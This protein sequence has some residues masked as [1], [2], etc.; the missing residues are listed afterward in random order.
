MHK[1]LYVEPRLVI[2]EDTISYA[3]DIIPRGNEEDRHELIE[4]S[5]HEATKKDTQTIQFTIR[6]NQ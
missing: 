4:E 3:S 6:L 5:Y 2:N 1:R